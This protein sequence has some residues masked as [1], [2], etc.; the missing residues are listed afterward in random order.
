MRLR[1]RFLSLP[2]IAWHHLYTDRIE[3]SSQ[4]ICMIK[5]SYWILKPILNRLSLF[6]LYS[7]LKKPFS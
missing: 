1:V 3:C 4:A 2:T 6:Q 7:L 5:F